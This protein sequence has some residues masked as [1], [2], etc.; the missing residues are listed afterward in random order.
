M[1]EPSGDIAPYTFEHHD[2]RVILLDGEPWWVLLDV[3]AAIGIANPARASTRLDSRDL[4][5][6]KVVDDHGSR[7]DT[8]AVNESG[9]YDLIFT[10][11]KPAAKRFKRWVTTEV[12][13]EIRRT[14]TYGLAEIDL[15]T[16]LERYAA[17]LREKDAASRR[18][19]E[20]ESYATELHPKAIEWDCYMDSNGLC[21]LGALAQALGGGRTRLI[22]RLQEL[23]VLISPAAAQRG[24]TRPTQ[25]YTELKW[26]KV[27]MEDTNVGPKYVS[28]ATPKGVSGVFRALVKHGVGEHR[29]GA[30]P[31]EQELF[32]VITFDEREPA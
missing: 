7:R 9:L 1:T 4:H 20:A 31:T 17:A 12:L 8:T 10:S 25:R 21:D 16:A 28:Y 27:I 18:A 3:C 26:F 14:G 22:R 6:V 29:W 19:I 15:P 23:G 13:P 24:G 2:V 11:R 32:K 5:T 30:L